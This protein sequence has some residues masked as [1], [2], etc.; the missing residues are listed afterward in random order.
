MKKILFTISIQLSIIVAQN[1]PFKSGE[2][3]IYEVNL[4]IISAG[5]A[6]LKIKDDEEL[7][8]ITLIGPSKEGAKLE[9]SKEFAKQFMQR[10]N[11]PTA[12]YQSFTKETLY[13]SS[14]VVA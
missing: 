8:D 10:H 1:Y 4:N 13:F 9:G 11:I 14:I 7:K 3:L 5:K 2:L 12:R 6:S